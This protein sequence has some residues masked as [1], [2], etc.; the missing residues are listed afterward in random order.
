MFFA[1]LDVCRSSRLHFIGSWKARIEA[2]M[3]EQPQ[4]P[5]AAAAAGGLRSFLEGQQ[6]QRQQKGAAAPQR[7]IVHLDMDCFFAAVAAVGRPEFAG[8]HL[9]QLS[10]D[11]CYIVIYATVTAPG[12]ATKLMI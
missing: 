7:V 6:Q 8:G 2:L 12:A 10:Y 9:A 4:Q 1:H 5:A 11:I 3:A